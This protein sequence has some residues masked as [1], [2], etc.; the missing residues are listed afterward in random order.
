MPK[1][2]VLIDTDVDIDDWMAILYLLLHPEVEVLGLTITGAGA[3][4]LSYGVKNAL[5][6]VALAGKP[7]TPVAAGARAPLLYSNCFPSSIRTEIDTTYNVALPANPNPPVSEGAVEFLVKTLTDAPEPVTILAIGGGTNLG[8]L[9]HD[10][11]GL[12]TKIAHVVMMGGA[13]GVPG[14]VN[15]VDPDYSNT[16][17]EWNIFIDPLGAKYLFDAGVKITL[18]PLDASN[19]VPINLAFY[20]RLQ[21]R[22]TTPAAAFIYQTFIAD[23]AFVQSGDFFAWD[24]LAATILTNPEIARFTDMKLSIVQQLD[25]EHDHSAQLVQTPD[26]TPVQVAMWADANAFYDLWLN[27][28]NV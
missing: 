14:N 9:L 2:P 4:H 20:D 13:I 15:V 10:N 26:G 8:T 27:G 21:Q 12:A 1:T 22:H 18:V 28:V 16:V 6:L 25:E 24:P 7:K 17:A 5:G 19:Y 3:S 11:P 23:I